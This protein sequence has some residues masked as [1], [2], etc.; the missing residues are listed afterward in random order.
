MCRISIKTRNI[1][2]KSGHITRNQPRRLVKANYSE[3]CILNMRIINLPSLMRNELSSSNVSNIY[4]ISQYLV[5]IW[6][7][8]SEST[9]TSS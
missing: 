1:W 7:Y 8:Y 4:K 6:S 3:E 2:F 5:Q 9:K